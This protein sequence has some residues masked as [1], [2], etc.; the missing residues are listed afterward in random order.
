M[1]TDLRVINANLRV[2]GLTASPYR[3]GHGYITD[4]PA[5]FDALIEPVSIEE[6]IFKGFLCNL[7]SKLT[8]T[9]LEVDGVK[10]RGVNT[11]NPSCKL[12]WTPTTKTAG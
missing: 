1:L 12:R 11:L 10:K 9:K 8:T 2:I 3:L 7:R 5:I 6:L 4:K